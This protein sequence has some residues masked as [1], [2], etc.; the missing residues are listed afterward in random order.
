[1]FSATLSWLLV[2]AQDAANKP[3]VTLAPPA[4]VS[5][6]GTRVDVGAYFRNAGQ[7]ALQFTPPVQI[8]AELVT[9]QSRMFVALSR[10]GEWKDDR[11]IAPGESL[12]VA[13]E[14]ELPP[15]AGGRVVLEL[16]RLAAP[17][18]V[19][20]IEPNTTL[21]PTAPEKPGEHTVSPSP[22]GFRY[23][24]ASLQRFHAYEPMYFVAGTSRPNVR[25]QFSFQYQIF[26]P[27]GPWASET[28]FLA[29]L[30]LGYTQTGLWDLEGTSVPFTDTNYKPEIAWSSEQVDW[31]KIPG[32]DQVGLQSGIQHESNGEDGDESR[33][34]SI[35]YVRPVLHFGDPK[36]FST[37]VAP[38]LY[39]YLSGQEN[40]TDI[41]QY[42]GYCD[43]KVTTG[44]IDGLQLTALGRLGSGGEN[45]SIQLDLTY[46]L[47][48][49][50]KGNFDM[51]LQLQYFAGYG[52]SLITYN[53]YTDALRI[54]IGFVR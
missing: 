38:K 28:P 25:F 46:P 32:V 5:K 16:T 47:R 20:E 13:Y 26:N 43:L 11:T 41:E 6:A 53:E 21:G 27:E 3:V 2:F 17:P 35:A 34:I 23:A 42:R 54:G 31:L 15:E 9:P 51:Y 49:I 48:A 24:E 37:Q 40:N 19:L 44:Y 52:E 8:D 10:K 39:F 22:G 7:D 4:A 29:G 18:S 36:G 50:G 14:L 33:S 12:F 45:G 30:F 1:M